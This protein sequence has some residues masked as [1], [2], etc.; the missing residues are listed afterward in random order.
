VKLTKAKFTFKASVAHRAVLVI[1][2]KKKLSAR[3]T[4]TDPAYAVRKGLPHA[5]AKFPMVVKKCIPL[6]KE[7][8]LAAD[9]IN[10]FTRESHKVM[11]NHPINL[12]RKKKGLLAANVILCRDA[13]NKAPPLYSLSKR[14]KK[15]WAILADMPLEIGI[16]RLAGM[17]VIKLP[18]PTFT[19][20]DFTIRIKKIVEAI[21]KYDCFYIHIKGPDLFGHDGDYMGKKKNIADIDKFFFSPLLKKI[22]LKNI[23][24]AITADHA[25]PCSLKGHSSDAVPFLISGKGIKPDSVKSFSERSCKKGGFG[26]LSDGQLFR[27]IINFI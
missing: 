8:A 4:N 24:I 22:D 23:V 3:I 27:T 9:L 20:K 10:E 12:R 15:R 18:L 16:G 26:K 5:L 25:T 7:A 6:E 1:K 17:K 14:Y 11:Q 21:K 2:A 13:G 19:K